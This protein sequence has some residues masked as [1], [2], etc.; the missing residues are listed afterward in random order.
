MVE[1]VASYTPAIFIHS[2]MVGVKSLEEYLA[3]SKNPT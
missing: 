1:L 2:P 3:E